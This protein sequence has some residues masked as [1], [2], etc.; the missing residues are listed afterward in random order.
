M[1]RLL[2]DLFK[3]G[4]YE[5]K[6]SRTS[7]HRCKTPSVDGIFFNASVGDIWRCN[8]GI[9][10][11]C[12]GLSFGYDKAWVKIIEDSLDEEGKDV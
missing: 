1:I 11:Q 2:F 9:R 3:G 7:K 12:I 10:Y 6:D 4:R 5:Y 8:C